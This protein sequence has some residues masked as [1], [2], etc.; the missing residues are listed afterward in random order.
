VLSGGLDQ[1][2][3][4]KVPHVNTLSDKLALQAA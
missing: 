1:V 4:K 2:W 3:V